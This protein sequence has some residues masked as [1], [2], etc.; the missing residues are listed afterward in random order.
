[1]K[2]SSKALCLP[3][4]GCLPHLWQLLVPQA[5]AQCH[6]FPG[7]V[8]PPE[9]PLTPGQAAC[10]TCHVPSFADLYAVFSLV[11]LSAT[12]AQTV[13]RG[14]EVLTVPWRGPGPWGAL[15]KPLLKQRA[16][17]CCCVQADGRQGALVSCS[18]C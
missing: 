13:F 15:S 8:G 11:L 17:R 16:P 3:L 1:M 6:L 18:P 10:L 2:P 9:L 7:A 14:P 4:P 5:R 12:G